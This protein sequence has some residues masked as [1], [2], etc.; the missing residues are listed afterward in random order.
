MAEY[1]VHEY[2]EI[3]N[4]CE[5]TALAVQMLKQYISN[6]RSPLLFPEITVDE[7]RLNKN[8]KAVIAPKTAA[9]GYSDTGEEIYSDSVFTP[10]FCSLDTCRISKSNPDVITFEVK[11]TC[12]SRCRT[13]VGYAYWMNFFA[14]CD[15]DELR[16]SAVYKAC[17]T[18]PALV[19][20]NSAFPDSNKVTFVY[21]P[22]FHGFCVNA[23]QGEKSKAETAKQESHEGGTLCRLHPEKH[24]L[25][26]EMLKKWKPVFEQY[27]VVV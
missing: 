8:G 16:A 1:V 9:R 11:Y 17:V 12:D 2:L 7:I 22:D 18:H 27:G 6:M 23:E 4:P 25:S 19:D 3:R 20:K 5:K 21:S 13:K 10:E 15:S 26:G 14:A 24:S